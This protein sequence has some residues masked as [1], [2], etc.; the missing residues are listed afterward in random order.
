MSHG[1][2]VTSVGRGGWSC[3]RHS[4]GPEQLLCH[5]V[6]WKGCQTQSH[7][8]GKVSKVPL[9]NL[10]LAGCRVMII[11][12]LCQGFGLHKA[13]TAGAE[14]LQQGR[15]RT[16]GKRCCWKRC[17]EGWGSLQVVSLQQDLLC[18][19]ESC[20]EASSH[21]DKEVPGLGEGAGTIPN[22]GEAGS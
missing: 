11:C 4:A 21:P 16:Q 22:P 14:D 18:S 13:G 12:C 10:S 2:D 20:R 8:E 17:C 9:G 5:T 15:S 3:S 7:R 6:G 19:T 1:S